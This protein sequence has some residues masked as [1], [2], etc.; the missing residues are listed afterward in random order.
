MSGASAPANTVGGKFGGSRCQAVPSPPTRRLGASGG[1]PRGRQGP[2]RADLA[3]D[4]NDWLAEVFLRKYAG[5]R[6]IKYWPGEAAG[7]APLA[8]T[9][10]KN[11][12]ETA[13]RYM[14][15]LHDRYRSGGHVR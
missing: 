7:S 9:L 13:G 10:H 1:L 3:K 11:P 12:A 4:R 5:Y 2:L 14:Q 15:N 8:L 6:F